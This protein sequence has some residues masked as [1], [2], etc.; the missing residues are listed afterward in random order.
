MGA[1]RS[2]RGS[3]SF[4][5]FDDG[6]IESGGAHGE[7]QF[8]PERGYFGWM[9]TAVRH[10]RL[11]KC[12]MGQRFGCTAAHSETFATCKRN[13]SIGEHGPQFDEAQI[14]DEAV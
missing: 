13:I 10:A 12:A 14:V 4:G 3:G 11:L 8:G 9:K 5:A 2:E 1:C 7:L 6:Q